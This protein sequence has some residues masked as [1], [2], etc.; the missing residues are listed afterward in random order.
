MAENEL[1][2]RNQSLRRLAL[3][4]VAVVKKKSMPIQQHGMYTT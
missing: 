2:R 4:I 1:H 3:A